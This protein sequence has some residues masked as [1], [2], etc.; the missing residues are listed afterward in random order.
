[1]MVVKICKIKKMPL[2][3][4]VRKQEQVDV[5]EGMGAENILNSSEEGW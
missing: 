2:I 3:N 5:L 1:M 4:I